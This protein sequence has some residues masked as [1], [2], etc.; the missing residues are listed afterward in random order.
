MP[1]LRLKI[2]A[3]EKFSSVTVLKDNFAN[4]KEKDLVKPL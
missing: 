1:V 2:E 3:L 4:C